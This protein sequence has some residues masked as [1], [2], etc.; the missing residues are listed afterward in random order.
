[1]RV[2]GFSDWGTVGKWSSPDSGESCP[3]AGIAI[4]P[5]SDEGLGRVNGCLLQAGRVLPLRDRK[6]T[7][8]RVLG[9]TAAPLATVA[10][11]QVL[12]FE[13]ATEL[14][15]DVSRANGL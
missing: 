1:M 14:G 15:V 3:W 8:E 10:S 7:V 9:T 5:E 4:G 2:E 13:H 11:L 12:L 6:Y